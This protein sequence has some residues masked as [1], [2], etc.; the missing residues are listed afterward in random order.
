MDNKLGLINKKLLFQRE[1]KLPLRSSAFLLKSL[2]MSL[3]TF[4]FFIYFLN[5]SICLLN[6]LFKI[7]DSLL[8]HFHFS[9]MLFPLPNN[10]IHVML[11]FFVHIANISKAFYTTSCQQ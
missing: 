8:I 6:I 10:F 3:R 9:A 11:V 1:K 7:I 5:S 4:A 2:T